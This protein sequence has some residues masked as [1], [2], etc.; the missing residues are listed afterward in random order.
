MTV[1]IDTTVLI[2]VSKGTPKAAAFFE[3]HAG[4]LLAS[5]ISRVEVLQGARAHELAL[6]EEL[7]EVIEW[8]PVFEEIAR[9]AGTLGQVWLRSHSGI[10]TP[11]LIIAASAQLADARLA[12]LNVK[13]FPMFPGLQPAY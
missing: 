11:D 10:D 6:I 12:T 9:R 5:E 1:I 2:D 13:H 8:I 7:F 3:R 4:E